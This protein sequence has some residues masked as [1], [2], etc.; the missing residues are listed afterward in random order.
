MAR[1]DKARRIA[2][3]KMTDDELSY[4]RV[5]ET[6][7]M[8]NSG[9]SIVRDLLNKGW[10]KP[11]DENILDQT[12]DGN[13]FNLIMPKDELAK[14]VKANNDLARAM[15]GIRDHGMVKEQTKDESAVKGEELL[16][17]A[18]VTDNG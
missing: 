6:V 5:T 3:E 12:P 11:E 10:I 7:D 8:R 18:G 9:Q 16:V 2:A 4:L 1:P 14:K 17:A 15:A 13:T